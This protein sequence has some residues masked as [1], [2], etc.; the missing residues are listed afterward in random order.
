MVCNGVLPIDQLR[1][2]TGPVAL[3]ARHIPKWFI[4]ATY[5]IN[6]V[7][8]S[9][10]EGGTGEPTAEEILVAYATARGF[11]RS[12]MGTPD[13][14]RAARYILK[15]Y[16]AGKLLYCYPPPD[17]VSP[18]EFNKEI[19]DPQKFESMFERKKPVG[20]ARQV[21]TTSGK[22]SSAKAP[23]QASSS[24]R[25]NALDNAFFNKHYGAP[26]I[27]GRF[28]DSGE[29]TRVKLYP[30]QMRVADDGTVIRD[31]SRQ[32]AIMAN[33]QDKKKSHKK[34]KKHIKNRHRDGYDD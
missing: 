24:R 1:E 28:A 13:E 5:G 25:V 17:S 12:G 15:D 2:Y 9:E 7:V 26:R 3:V 6:I 16:V 4:E 30:H 21:K 31:A 20:E 34:G 11:M 8:R 14:S 27:R 22:Q 10:E 23:G 19:H 33:F 18:E 29:F 32:E